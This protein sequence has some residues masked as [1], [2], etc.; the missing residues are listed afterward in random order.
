MTAPATP[1]TATSTGID[2]AEAVRRLSVPASLFLDH[3][4]PFVLFDGRGRCADLRIARQVYVAPS[5]LAALRLWLPYR[6]PVLLASSRVTPA[7]HGWCFT[8]CSAPP[9]M[10]R[11]RRCGRRRSG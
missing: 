2:T 1:T 5:D 3:E 7:A 6:L 9:P 10:G 11:S 8:T 4:P